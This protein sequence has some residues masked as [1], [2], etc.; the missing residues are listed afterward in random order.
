MNAIVNLAVVLSP[1][2]LMGIG[3]LLDELLFG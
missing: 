2:I 3:V 1:V